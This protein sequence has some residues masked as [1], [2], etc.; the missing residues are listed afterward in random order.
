AH[1]NILAFSQAVMQ[2]TPEDSIEVIV[3]RLAA[4]QGGSA[5]DKS[6]ETRQANHAVIV[7]FHGGS[8]RG[9]TIDALERH[10]SPGG[11]KSRDQRFCNSG[12]FQ[13]KHCGRAQ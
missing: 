10:N 7:S 6:A 12:F 8:S 9:V 4:D 3:P 1:R 5:I 2:I 11:E 13:T